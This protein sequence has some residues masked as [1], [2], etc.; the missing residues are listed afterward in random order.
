[1]VSTLSRR[2]FV[3]ARVGNNDGS[4]LQHTRT[5]IPL[6]TDSIR[7]TSSMPMAPA[8][9]NRCR[10]RSWKNCGGFKLKRI[11]FCSTRSGQASVTSVEETVLYLIL[12]ILPFDSSTLYNA[13]WCLGL[14]L[15]GTTRNKEK[16]GDGAG[17]LFCSCFED[18]PFQFRREDGERIFA[19]VHGGGAKETLFRR[20]IDQ[21]SFDSFKFALNLERFSESGPDRT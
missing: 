10:T 14:P 3:P 11:A 6:Q 16:T 18:L 12:S 19:C 2:S 21:H 4:E 17:I 8:L 1:M 7:F 20:S 5:W 9:T 13:E 15:A